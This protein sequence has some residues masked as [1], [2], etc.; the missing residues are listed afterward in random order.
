MKSLADLFE[1]TLKDIYFAEKQ[2]V[3]ALP[4]MAKKASSEDLSD[5]FNT[6]ALFRLASCQISHLYPGSPCAGT[7]A[8]W[9]LLPKFRSR[10]VGH[11]AYDEDRDDEPGVSRAMQ[12]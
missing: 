8:T 11:V 3:K 7:A 12:V 6:L 4:K 5:A 10:P 9:R 2:I 1:D